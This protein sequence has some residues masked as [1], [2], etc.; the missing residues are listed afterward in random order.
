MT[1]KRIKYLVVESGEH[2]DAVKILFME[3]ARSL[4][5]S[6]G[7]QDFEEEIADLPGHYGP[8]DGCILL[9]FYDDVPVACVALRKLEEGICEMKRLYVK[10]EFRRWGI[11]IA[12]SKKIIDEA[13]R[14]GYEKMRLDT[15]STMKEAISIYR[16]LGFRDIE[17]YRYNPFNHAVF[18]EKDL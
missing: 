11:G 6:L 17:P 3:Y 12:L 7:F 2:L 16:K 1:E 5:F 13:K 4:E 9:A 10:P 18:L 15:L 14:I 8:P